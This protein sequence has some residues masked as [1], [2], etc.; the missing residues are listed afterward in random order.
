[1]DNISLCA[2]CIMSNPLSDV[3]I[4]RKSMKDVNV[5]VCVCQHTEYVGEKQRK[6]ACIPFSSLAV[7]LAHLSSSPEC[8]FQLR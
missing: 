2:V 5:C 7:L 1:M 3:T 8:Y 6:A 4:P